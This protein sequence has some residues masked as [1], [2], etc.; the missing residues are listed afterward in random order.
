MKNL[1]KYFVFAIATV[2]VAGAVFL[3][4]PSMN[5]FASDEGSEASP[6]S[7]QGGS[8]A[9]QSDP[10]LKLTSSAATVYVGGELQLKVSLEGISD[11]GNN[12]IQGVQWSVGDSS[13]LR[14]YNY[15]TTFWALALKPGTT[16][17]T[18]SLDNSGTTLTAKCTVTV[19]VESSKQ[20][21]SPSEQRS[22]S[23]SAA[24]TT[25]VALPANIT[26]ADGKPLTMFSAVD[27]SNTLMTGSVGLI[28]SGAKLNAVEAAPTS[29]TY[30][31]ATAI[32]GIWRPNA[33]VK[34]V[35]DFN[36]FSKQAT[37]IKTLDGKVCMSLPMPA[38]LVVPEG[39]VLK[40]YKFNDDGTITVCETLIDQGRVVW[41][42]DSFGTFAFA[43]EKP[44]PV[45]ARRR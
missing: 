40:V 9:T 12:L 7:G 29:Q 5:T 41:G 44:A 20:N 39:M 42:T 3:I 17:I 21:A 16:D 24:S 6:D 34:K 28:P 43:V 45:R 32:L 10:A 36:V 15:G 18:A 26:S 13:L 11:P 14:I 19:P 27:G 35:Y 33:E 38:D 37:A 2:I 31:V 22:S 25:E 1:K 8:G 23:S 4:T 30:S